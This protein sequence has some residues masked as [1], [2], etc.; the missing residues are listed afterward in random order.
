MPGIAK[1]EVV[2]ERV[3]DLFSRGLSGGQIAKELGITPQTVSYYRKALGLKAGV[4]IQQ[5]SV[6]T[7]KTIVSLPPIPKAKPKILLEIEQ[8]EEEAAR[9]YRENLDKPQ[10]IEYVKEENSTE[11]KKVNA[12]RRANGQPPLGG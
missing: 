12:F 6:I 9:V 3:R 8:E 2:R 1:N 11:L 10:V 5:A 4:P 7:H